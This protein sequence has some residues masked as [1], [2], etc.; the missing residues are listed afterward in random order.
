MWNNATKD[1]AA[2]VA[3]VAALDETAFSKQSTFQAHL[4]CQMR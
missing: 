1:E 4:S 2:F 3:N